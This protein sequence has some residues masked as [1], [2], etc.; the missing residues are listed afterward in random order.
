MDPWQLQ[1]T[2]FVIAF[3]AALITVPLCRAL[4]WKIN[5]LDKPLS[6]G[7]KRHVKATPVL[8][9]LGMVT[10]WIGTI[11]GGL[12]LAM[13]GCSYIP[14]DLIDGIG[15]GSPKF[16]QLMA[17]CGGVLAF[18]GLGMWDDRRPMS[19]KSKLGGQMLI[20]LVVAHWGVK[21]D[22]LSGHPYLSTLVCWAWMLVILNAINILDNMDGLVAGI[23]SIASLF[24][25]AAAA[26]QGQFL[27]GMLSA[28]TCAVCCG[29]WFYNRNPATIFMGD[30]GSHF[31]GFMLGVQG[32]LVTWSD[33]GSPAKAALPLLLP[34]LILAIPLFDLAAVI[35]IRMRNRKP[36]YIGDHNHISHRFV[37][38]GFSRKNAVRLIHLLSFVIGAGALALLRSSPAVGMI[39]CAQAIGLLIFVTI[40]HHTQE[41]PS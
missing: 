22:M 27:V 5:F 29:F 7:H 9:G 17:I 36:I 18:L 37:R 14:A 2:V 13:A 38:M 31:V 26:I 32:F 33:D 19:A 34:F 28:V 25:A 6:E 21:I 8:G 12:G 41:T 40:L 10:A 15:P 1:I 24:F 16:I 11:G 23:G 3:S 20:L 39:L 30:A 35:I 4:A